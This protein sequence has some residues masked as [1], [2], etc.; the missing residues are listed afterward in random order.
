MEQRMLA[1]KAD[2]SWPYTGVDK[3][4]SEVVEKSEGFLHD[5]QGGSV[6]LVSSG[7]V[8]E[9][10]KSRQTLDHLGGYEACDCT[11]KCL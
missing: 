2:S 7:E 10:E 8:R 11:E 9:I 3:D 5:L 4:A 1:G 6:V